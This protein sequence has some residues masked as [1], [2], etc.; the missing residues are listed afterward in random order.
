MEGR[1]LAPRRAGYIEALGKAVE[2][3]REVLPR[4]P[5]VEPVVL[6]G[7]YARG[8][9]DLFTDLDVLVVMRPDKPF[10]ERIASS[11]AN[12]T[13]RWTW[14]SCAILPRSSRP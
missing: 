8:R 4:M 1:S 11:T 2:R 6:F 5:E 12:S 10:V 7:S 14:T 9:R 13:C 3:I